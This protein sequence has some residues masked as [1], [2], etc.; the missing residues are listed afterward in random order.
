MGS[1]GFS[2]VNSRAWQQTN[3]NIPTTRRVFVT[4][5]NALRTALPP[6]GTISSM[7]SHVGMLWTESGLASVRFLAVNPAE[8]YWVIIRPELM[9]G[10][11]V[12]KLGRKPLECLLRSLSVSRSQRLHR[13]DIRMHRISADIAMYAPWKLP[14]D[15]TWSSMIRG[16][17]LTLFI[18]LT[19]LI[20]R[21]VCMSSIGPSIWGM[22]RRE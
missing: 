7:F 3:N 15:I 2:G 21:V 13:L 19:V 8:T 18:S 14:P 20:S 17:S 16:L 6:I 11:D 5:S 22:Q 10:L 1:D 4:D 12:R 9:P